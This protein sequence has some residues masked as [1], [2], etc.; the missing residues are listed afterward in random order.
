MS[1]SYSRGPAASARNATGEAR[2]DDVHEKPRFDLFFGYKLETC[3]PA[4]KQGLRVIARFELEAG[5]VAT[6]LPEQ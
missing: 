1:N 5:E 6:Q 2:G 4:A 3:F